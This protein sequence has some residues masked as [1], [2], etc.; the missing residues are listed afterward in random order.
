MKP[1]IFLLL[2]GFTIASCQNGSSDGAA[3]SDTVK[4]GNYEF[5]TIPGSEAQM[6]TLRAPAGNVME[7]GA[8]RN[9][10]KNGTW[11]FFGPAGEFPLQ[12]I[13]FVDDQYNGIYLEFNERQQVE[14]MANYKNN[15]LDGPYGK[16]RFGRPELTVNYIDGELDGIMREYDF[17]NGK[18]KKEASYKAGKLDGLV[19]DFDDEGQ[20]MVEYMYR[21]GEKISGG[22]VERK[23]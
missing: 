8:M 6:A 7:T 10:K 21:D 13:S 12:L 14:L 17:R 1:F 15:K 19:R 18:L 9:G 16:Y 4:V 23:E 3:S 22:I 11:T 5:A 2:L 20:V